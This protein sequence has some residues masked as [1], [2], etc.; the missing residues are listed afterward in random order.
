VFG[1]A[2]EPMLGASNPLSRVESDLRGPGDPPPDRPLPRLGRDG[3]P[4][5]PLLLLVALALLAV[6]VYV[7]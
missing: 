3:L 5:A 4:L 2:R 6:R 1:A 7:R